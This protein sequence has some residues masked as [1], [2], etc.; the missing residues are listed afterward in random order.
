MG[1]LERGFTNEESPFQETFGVRG[2]A[3]GAA[4]KPEIARRGRDAQVLWPIHLLLDDERPTIQSISL[5]EL[6]LRV[7]ECPKIVEATRDIWMVWSQDRLTDC[8]GSLEE[9][10]SLGV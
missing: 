6:P 5:L 4:E 1:C 7:V 9:R 8:Q 3:C 10:L 2:F